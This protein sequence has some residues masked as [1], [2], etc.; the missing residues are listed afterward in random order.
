MSLG[1]ES[2]HNLASLHFHQG[3]H[4]MQRQN[5][6]QY[7]IYKSKFKAIGI[8][9]IIIFAQQMI[10]KQETNSHLTTLQLYIKLFNLLIN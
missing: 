7:E 10:S 4:D 6:L 1:I 3:M 2:N 5:I 9:T 8:S